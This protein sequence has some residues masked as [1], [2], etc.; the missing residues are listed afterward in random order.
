MGRGLRPVW[1]VGSQIKLRQSR[2]VATMWL[3]YY[4]HSFRGSSFVPEWLDVL[5][6]FSGAGHSRRTASC[7]FKFPGNWS[8]TRSAQTHWSLNCD[9]LCRAQNDASFCQLVNISAPTWTDAADARDERSNWSPGL[10]WPMQE[11]LEL[12]A[13]KTQASSSA[14][15]PP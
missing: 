6:T 1:W 4:A 3:P 5:P 10:G 2:F 11:G 13:H 14:A 7:P 9:C 15:A 12:P 8:L